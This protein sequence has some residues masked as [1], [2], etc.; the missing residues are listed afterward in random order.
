MKNLLLL[1]ILLNSSGLIAQNLIDNQILVQLSPQ[2]TIERIIDLRDSAIKESKLISKR[3]NIYLLT[4]VDAL[5][6][7]AY[8]SNLQNAQDVLFVHLNM[9]SSLRYVPND[10]QYSEQWNL[11]I[12]G[13]E[14]VWEITKGGQ[15]F[16]DKEIVIAVIDE[17]FKVHDDLEEN[18]WLNQGEIANNGID[19]DNNGY[20]DDR[21]GLNIETGNDVH[22]EVDHG[23][24]VSSI[25]GAK[26]D[27]NS[28]MTGINFDVKIMLISEAKS[29]SEIVEAYEYVIDQ[30]KRFNDSNGTEGAFVVVTNFSAGISN[31]FGSDWP[32][33]C[34][35]YDDLG[36]EGVLSVSA[37]PNSAVNV[38]IDG[39]LPTTCE[40]PYLITTTNTTEFDVLSTQ[41]GFGVTH[42]DLGAPGED[43]LVTRNTNEYRFGSGT[44]FSCPHIAGA[45]G[46]LYSL[47]CPQIEA[48][49]FDNPSKIA[50]DV[51][52]AIMEN[53]KTIPSLQSKT[54]SGG[55]IDLAG[56]TDA[57]QDVCDSSVGVI[58]LNVSLSSD[59][60][61]IK[62]ETPDFAEYTIDILD[63]VGRLVYTQ[64]ISPPLFG[65]KRII[66]NTTPQGIPS[67]AFMPYLPS[68]MYIA[69]LYNDS[70]VIT[71]KF[72]QN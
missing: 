68:G 21:R 35:L 12:I 72:Y 47:P 3:Q 69:M 30:R 28:G 19:D 17:G 65:S 46:L 26:G 66:L 2:Q 62:Y 29:I 43:V 59:F 60:L 39:D 45:V 23:T 71:Q 64:K 20:V 1:T 16:L 52:K 40:S 31:Q 41:A 50:E 11:E 63:M 13:A 49:I 18:I 54:V 70:N 25:L 6:A 4:L 36:K 56:A 10:P 44:S 22:T 27:N 58:E 51:K 53:V 7:E 8:I 32:I 15:T 33:W 57:L 9:E 34:D 37:V 42:V 61:C 24:Q 38:D 14:D 67:N 48:G 5:S 55:R